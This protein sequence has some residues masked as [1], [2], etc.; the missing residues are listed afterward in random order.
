MSNILT[1]RI[2][3]IIITIISLSF[4]FT[5][6]RNSQQQTLAQTSASTGSFVTSENS[7]YRFKIQYPS[8]WEKVEF[9]PGIR[10][11]GRNIIVN[12]ISP[13][14]TFSDLFR[15]YLI[16]EVQDHPSNARSLDQYVS[17]Q[18]DTYKKSLPR[19]AVIESN[20]STPTTYTNVDHPSHK[21]VYSYSDSTVGKAEIMEINM[22]EGNRLYSLSYHADAT[23]YS[24]YLPVI[25]KMIKSF[26]PIK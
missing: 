6:T 1:F 4:S 25:E 2:I 22:I 13:Q 20:A 14:E 24:S 5:I 3:I 8:N 10:E 16:I 12:F 17:Q 7:N 23:K 21:L 26:E 19:F 11:S 18:I 15:E 9:S